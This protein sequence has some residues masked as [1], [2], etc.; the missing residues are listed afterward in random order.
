MES[1]RLSNPSRRISGGCGGGWRE[2]GDG[3]ANGDGPFLGFAGMRGI[4]TALSMLAHKAGSSFCVA[5]S[6]TA[7]RIYCRKSS[8]DH[9]LRP[10]P[11]MENSSASKPLATRLH[12]E[13]SSFRF[14][15]SPD[16]PKITMTYGPAR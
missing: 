3:A 16:A 8:S 13:G 7:S 2:G 10:I 15:K 4:G 5:N 6:A 9:S 11:L 12:R 14:V 1:N